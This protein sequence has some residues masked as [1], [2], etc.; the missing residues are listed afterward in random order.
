ME[1]FD[2]KNALEWLGAI[3]ISVGGTSAIVI[4]ISK[5]F[6]DRLATKLLEKDRSKYQQELE[7]LKTKYQSELEIKKAE[8]EKSKSLF[9]RYSE[10][11]FNLYNDLWK[12]LCDLKH[13]GEELWEKAEPQLT[14]KFSKQLRET[15]LTVEKSALLIEDGHYKSLT[16]I[17]DKFGNFEI[18]KLRLINLRNKTVHEMNEYGVRN[19]EIRNVIENNRQT[20]QEYIKLTKELSSSF[21]AQIKGE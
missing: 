21:K 1:N 16:T 3:I 12:S 7:A 15:K 13:I 14:K 2:I 5:W 4:A 6:G 20:K 10:H 11:Q 9:L 17:L 19:N 8:L 18:G